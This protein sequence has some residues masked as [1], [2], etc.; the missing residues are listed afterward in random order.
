MVD[1]QKTDVKIV[2]SLT[3]DDIGGIDIS[4]KDESINPPKNQL[5]K[6]ILV[7]SGTMIKEIIG[8]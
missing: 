3:E 1:K 6:V 8:E 4:I 7:K 5:N 2:I